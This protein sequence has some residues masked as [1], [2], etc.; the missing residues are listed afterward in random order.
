MDSGV[1]LR[2]GDPADAMLEVRVVL[3]AHKTDFPTDEEASL[4]DR[5]RKLAEGAV[6]DGFAEV[7]TA[8]TRVPDPGDDELTLDTHY[9]ITYAKRAARLDDAVIELKY[10]L[11]LEKRA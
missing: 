11:G 2:L 3:S 6:S 1:R 7:G 4:F 9:E 5:V 8:V 10:A